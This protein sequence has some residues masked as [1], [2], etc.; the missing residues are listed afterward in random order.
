M[1]EAPVRCT[2]PTTPTTP[3]APIAPEVE[4]SPQPPVPVEEP[5]DTGDAPTREPPA[6]PDQVDPPVKDP[7][8][9]G[10]PT[11]KQVD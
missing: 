7:R 5:P 3:T 4:E 11:R 1:S 2:T 9:P 8:V 6:G 10:R